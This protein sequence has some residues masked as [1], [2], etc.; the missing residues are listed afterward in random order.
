MKIKGRQAVTPRKYR[1]SVFSR[2]T[3]HDTGNPCGSADSL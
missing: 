2:A 1:N 3:S